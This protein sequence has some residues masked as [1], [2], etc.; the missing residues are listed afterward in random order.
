MPSY[1]VKRYAPLLTK[2]D[3]QMLF[4]WLTDVFGSIA[5]AAEVT[6]VRRKTIY[7][8]ETSTENVRL[9]TK[10]KVLEQSMKLDENRTL[11]FLIRKTDNDLG[12]VFEHYLRCLVEN[13]M[14]TDSK[15]DFLKYASL[16]HDIQRTHRGAVFDSRPED[17]REMNAELTAK[18]KEFQVDIAEPPVD[19]IPPEILAEKTMS[20]LKIL[21]ANKLTIEEMK[22]SFDLPSEYIEKMAKARNYLGP[23]KSADMR[24]VGLVTGVVK[25]GDLIPP[26]FGPMGRKISLNSIRDPRKET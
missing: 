8:W 23:G 26:E 18:A 6:K 4:R 12:E 20:L 15:E 14:K 2:Y 21:E 17:I 16:F 3:V 7:D 24:E 19:L 22:K 9:E 25:I 10:I 13:A 1:I 11:E 5:K